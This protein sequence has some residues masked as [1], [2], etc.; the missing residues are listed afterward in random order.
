MRGSKL[1]SDNEAENTQDGLRLMFNVTL[2]RNKSYRMLS[3]LQFYIRNLLTI[4]ELELIIFINS[5]TLEF[6]LPNHLFNSNRSKNVTK[7]QNS[8]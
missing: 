4:D 5:F 7:I 2:S 8:I 3:F 6:D 1:I